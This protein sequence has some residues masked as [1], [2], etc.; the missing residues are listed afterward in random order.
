MS[1]DKVR[2]QLSALIDDEIDDV[3]R[4]LLLGRLQRDAS[5]SASLGR[6]ELIGEVMRNGAAQISE[7]GVASR[8]RVALQQDDIHS[9]EAPSVA[10]PHATENRT[11]NATWKMITGFA[12]AASVAVVLVFSIQ[13]LESGGSEALLTAENAQIPAVNSASLLVSPIQNV[14]EVETSSEQWDR[15]EPSVERRLSGYLVNHNEY[16]VSDAMRGAMPY[17][18]VVG[19]EG[20]R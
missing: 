12:V 8:V 9:M 19:F 15:I 20:Y 18:R 11:S 14:A 13:N 16:A 2:E 3:E 10:I 17:V 1:D 6:Y 7:T 5:L 4:P